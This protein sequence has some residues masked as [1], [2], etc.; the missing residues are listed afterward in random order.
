MI[1][2]KSEITTYENK[3]IDTEK[4]E[5]NTETNRR[6]FPYSHTHTHTQNIRHFD[7]RFQH[8]NFLPD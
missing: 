6:H 7:Q 4:K 5:R 2:I 8:L 1:E 3:K